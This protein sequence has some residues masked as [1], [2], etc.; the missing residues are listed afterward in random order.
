MPLLYLHTVYIILELFKVITFKIKNILSIF[1]FI[2]IYINIFYF[3]TLEN[4]SR[5]KNT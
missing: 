1:S 4:I 5:L 3:M 2:T